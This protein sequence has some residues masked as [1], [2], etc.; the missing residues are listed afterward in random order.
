MILLRQNVRVLA[1]SALCLIGL[2][3]YSGGVAN[4]DDT[5]LLVF[6]SASLRDVMRDVGSAYEQSTGTQI[7]FNFAGS[8]VLAR[9]I[10]ASPRADIYLSAN[11]QWV[12]YLAERELIEADSKRV[13]LSNN[14][15][16]VSSVDSTWSLE[17]PKQLA[18]IPFK[19][20]S[21]GDPDAVP[22]GRY[23]KQYLSKIKSGDI[24]PVTQN[25]PGT[26]DESVNSLG[27]TESVWSQVSGRVLPAPD[28]RA[29]ASAVSHMPSMI[30]IIYKT[31]AIAS[32]KLKV[33]YE[34]DLRED[35]QSERVKYVAAAVSKTKPHPS[36]TEFLNFIM[37]NQAQSIFT[38]HGFDTILDDP[39]LN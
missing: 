14:L 4:D 27:K 17:H 15:V 9:Q 39:T 24:T 38:A 11:E 6:A 10:E 22:A 5:A 19:F 16:V 32:S 23:A 1:F 29:A 25:K 37:D 2:S 34:I 7:T 20:L 21:L 31:D 35:G 8:N 13:F 36:A 3:S 18:S 26:A 33:L 28:V 30:G 12:T